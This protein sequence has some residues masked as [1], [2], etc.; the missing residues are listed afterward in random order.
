MIKKKARERLDPKRLDNNCRPFDELPPE[1]LEHIC[2]YL[3]PRSLAKAS[4]VCNEW[5]TVASGSDHSP[6]LDS[7]ASTLNVLRNILP[8]IVDH[9]WKSHYVSKFGR[10]PY[11]TSMRGSIKGQ[12]ANK[13][14]EEI[15]A[16]RMN[17]IQPIEYGYRQI[18]HDV[19]YIHLCN[20]Q[21]CNLLMNV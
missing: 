4:I 18:I 7:Y 8:L 11:L 20:F 2:S 5:N 13:M 17:E 9:L 14:E 3:D 15:R 21:R 1:L 12:F 19:S 6:T 10:L 16:K